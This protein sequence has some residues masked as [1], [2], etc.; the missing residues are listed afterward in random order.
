MAVRL[1]L[2]ESDA[3]AG[4]GGP[5]SG[6]LGLRRPRRLRR[7]RPFRTLRR[8]VLLL[9]FCF[10]LFILPTF[11][12]MAGDVPSGKPRIVPLATGAA[13]TFDPAVCA[14]LPVPESRLCNYGSLFNLAGRDAQ[15][16]P[17][18]IAAVAYV[19]SGY[20][21]DVIA[22]RRAS[23]DGALGIMQFLPSTA[24]ERGVDPC[25]VADAVFGGAGYLRENFE[26]FDTWELAIAAYNAGPTGVTNA[27]GIPQNGETEKYVPAVMAKWEQYKKL[28]RGAVADCPVSPRGT[29]D[30]IE[31]PGTT[32]ATM[33]MADAVIGCFGREYGVDCFDDSAWREDRFEH[34]RGRACDFMITSGGM[35][36][37]TRKVHG[38][39]MAEW[40]MANAEE[41]NLLYVIWY[42]RIW[43]LSR[44]GATF[45][46]WEEW[47]SY[48]CDGCDP[49]SAHYNHVHISVKL[50]PGDPQSARCTHDKCTE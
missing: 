10:V 36:D 40:A 50:M 29:T 9:V 24:A 7:P 18:L 39:A 47:R 13:V 14:T 16:D 44:D 11:L 5:G 25:D 23:E 37:D 21:E 15:V 38:Q 8:I 17:R 33:T 2:A 28:F 4:G 46:P 27:G 45:R 22:C 43:S 49:S 20:E 35:P 30:P 1:G 32:P 41:L 12:A 42:N 31:D 3:P 19:E 26:S 6:L 34:P 48:G